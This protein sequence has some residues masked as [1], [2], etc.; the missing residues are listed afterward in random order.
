MSNV[1]PMH[2]F[3]LDDK[4]PGLGNDRGEI[5]SSKNG[6]GLCKTP[7]F[8]DEQTL[9][10]K[11]GEG[12]NPASSLLCLDLDYTAIILLSAPKPG[13]HLFHFV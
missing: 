3:N 2:C 4:P 10:C 12:F 6:A 7:H 9:L 13:F 8:Q 5:Y 1:I 11:Q